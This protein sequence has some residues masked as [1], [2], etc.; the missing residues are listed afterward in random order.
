MVT[1]VRIMYVLNLQI[2]INLYN[3][4]ERYKT[5]TLDLLRQNPVEPVPQ[6][7]DLQTIQSCVKSLKNNK[8]AGHDGICS[9]HFKLMA[10]IY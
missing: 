8:T 3:A 1:L 5:E 6:L 10:R 4:D 2:I 9:K 7:A